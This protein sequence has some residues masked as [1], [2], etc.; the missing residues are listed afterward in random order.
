M[1]GL[2]L[3]IN[4]FKVIFNIN[5]ISVSEWVQPSRCVSFS[6]SSQNHQSHHW[7]P[8]YTPLG[9]SNQSER[10]ISTHEELIIYS[11]RQTQLKNEKKKS[12][13]KVNILLAFKF[14]VILSAHVERKTPQRI[15][16]NFQ[17]TGSTFFGSLAFTISSGV[18]S[19]PGNF[20]YHCCVRLISLNQQT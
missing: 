3:C 16:H 4:T 12:Q 13:M 17:N 8:S 6:P 19:F 20:I 5:Q 10:R 15:Q 7:R 1:I 18:L 2:E 9:A 14:Q 11:E